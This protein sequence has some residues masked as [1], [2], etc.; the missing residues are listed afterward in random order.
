MMAILST[1]RWVNGLSL[2]GFQ[3]IIWSN[4]DILATGPLT[5]N[6]SQICT[7]IQ[8][9]SGKKIN[10]NQHQTMLPNFLN[11]SWIEHYQACNIFYKQSR[12]G[13]NC[14]I[15]VKCVIWKQIHE[16]CESVNTDSWHTFSNGSS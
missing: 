10:L 8:E 2:F 12:N 6:F 5:T 3:D 11:F 14:Q 15:Y 13:D 16:K 1:R 9:F 4:A 7:E